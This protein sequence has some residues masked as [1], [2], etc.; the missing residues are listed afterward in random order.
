VRVGLGVAAID[1]AIH[2]VV[3]HFNT[4]LYVKDALR[5]VAQII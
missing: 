3:N 5:A 4:V 2:R 1:V